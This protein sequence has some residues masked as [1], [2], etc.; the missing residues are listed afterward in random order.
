MPDPGALRPARP[1]LFIDG[2]ERP[3]LAGGLL[4]MSAG[5]GRDGLA[6][7][8]LRFTNWGPAGRGMDFLYFDR[9]L[10]D[11]GAQLEVRLERDTLFAGRISAIE[12]RFPAGTPPEVVV[13]AED[14]LQAL[15]MARNTRVWEDVSDA[16]LIQAIAGAHGLSARTD[17]S[18]PTHRSVAQTNETDLGFLRRRARLGG[19]ELWAE[20]DTLRAAPRAD[21]RGSP[22]ELT[23]GAGLTSFRVIA[24]ATAPAGR[25]VVGGWDVAGKEAV[26]AVDTGA[27]LQSEISQGEA[28]WRIQADKLAERVERVAHL[29]AADAGAAQTLAAAWFAHRARAFVRGAGVAETSAG[30]KVGAAVHLAGLGDLFSG[31][32][33]VTAVFHRFDAEKGLRTEFEVERAWIGRPL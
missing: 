15:R 14:R 30:L 13:L 1:S 29:Q 5:E 9:T 6:R 26:A 31:D 12:A 17:V 16:D 22:T 32:Y 10:L 24:D 19:Y 8:E 21:R 25:V 11:F 23:R 20:G 3:A 28:G 7:C 2:E 27:D 33:D 18:G 4:E